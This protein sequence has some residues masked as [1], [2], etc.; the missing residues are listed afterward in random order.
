MREKG[1][2]ERGPKAHSK[3]LILVPHMTGHQEEQ[4]DFLRKLLLKPS[5][6]CRC[7]TLCASFLAILNRCDLN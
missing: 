6:F 2:E 3:T 1:L 7:P 5:S 4:V